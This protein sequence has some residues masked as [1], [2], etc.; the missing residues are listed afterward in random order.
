[1][2]LLSLLWLEIPM[3]LPVQ[4]LH[5]PITIFFQT[6]LFQEAPV[7]YKIPLARTKITKKKKI[8]LYPYLFISCQYFLLEDPNWNQLSRKP[9]KYS[10][11]VSNPCKYRR[12]HRKAKYGWGPRD[13]NWHMQYPHIILVLAPFW[14]LNI[15]ECAQYRVKWETVN[16]C[17]L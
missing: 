3:L 14:L 2:T 6:L 17:I 16:R 9:L 8:L 13:Q 5:L 12:K 4:S 15:L 11:L 7:T 10:L 1:M